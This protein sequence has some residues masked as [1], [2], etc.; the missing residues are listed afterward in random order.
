[1]LGHGQRDV[2]TP[3]RLAAIHTP[4]LIIHGDGDNLIAPSSARHFKDAIPGSQ[5]VML[6]DVGHIPQEEAPDDSAN[7]VRTFLQHALHTRPTTA[8]AH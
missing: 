3:E 6:H 5:L 1:M 7:A 8:T 2:A 4:T